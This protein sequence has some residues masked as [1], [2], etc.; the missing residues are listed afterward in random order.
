M[1]LEAAHRLATA[2]AE[3]QAMPSLLSGLTTLL[4]N[5]GID[6]CVPDDVGNSLVAEDDLREVMVAFSMDRWIP[7]RQSTIEGGIYCNGMALTMQRDDSKIK[8]MSTSPD[9]VTVWIK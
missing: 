7:L 8:L 3:E 6:S 5:Q 4:A 2:L 1:K 9:R